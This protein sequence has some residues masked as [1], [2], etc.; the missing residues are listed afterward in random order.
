MQE[1]CRFEHSGT[2]CRGSTYC[3]AKNVAVVGK[4]ETYGSEKSEEVAA[5]FGVAWVFPVNCMMLCLYMNRT[6]IW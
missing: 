5:L 1:D 4:M 2:I 6:Q 3:G